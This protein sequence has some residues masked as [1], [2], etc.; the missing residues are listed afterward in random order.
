MAFAVTG[1]HLDFGQDDRD[2]EGERPAPKHSWVWIIF[3]TDI[4]NGKEYLPLQEAFKPL[5][6]SHI[7]YYILEIR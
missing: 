6:L 4:S 7:Q 2:T 1:E 3:T 5:P